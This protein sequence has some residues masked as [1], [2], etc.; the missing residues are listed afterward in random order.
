MVVRSAMLGA[1]ALAALLAGEASAE[2]T[3]PTTVVAAK[4]GLPIALPK[5]SSDNSDGDERTDELLAAVSGNDAASV[6]RLLAAATNVK[7]T[8][9]LGATAL[10]A[11]A[12]LS[13]PEI[14]NKLLAAGGDPNVGLHSGETPLMAAA[15]QG[16]LATV[17]ALLAGGAN[18]DA[19]ES[20]GGQ[21]ALMWAIAERHPDVVE[22]LIKRGADVRARTKEGS[23]ALMFAAQ[24]T[25]ARFTRILL[26]AGADANDVMTRTRTT[27]LLIASAMGHTDVAVA[28]LDKS[29][30]PNAVDSR[31][32]TPLHHAVRDKRAL[33]LVN[34]LLQHGADPN[35]RMAQSKPVTFTTTYIALRGATPMVLAA[36]INNFDAVKTLVAGGGDPLISTDSKTTALMLAAGAGTDVVRPRGAAERKTAIETVKFLVEHGADVIGIGEYGWT[37]LHAAAYQGLNDV[38]SYLVSKGGKLDTLDDFGQTPRSIAETILTRKIGASTLQIPR[39]F[40]KDTLELLIKLGAPTPEASGVDIVFRRNTG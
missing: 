5:V 9:D 8:N 25:D 4:S 18:P 29:A 36:E 24:Q 6:D 10:Y 30:N 39:I 3:T 40:R 14:T 19:H 15:F 7:A 28:L 12:A 20:N 33:K 16:N 32:F 2:L 26:G 38:I 13:D 37:P 23:T 31:G 27:P 1:A 21:T 35:I 11:A 22:T 17:E 34:A